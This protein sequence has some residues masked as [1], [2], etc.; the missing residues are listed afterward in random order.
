MLMIAVNNRVRKL[1]TSL[2]LVSPVA[3]M[4]S[5]HAGFGRLLIPPAFHAGVCCRSMP[6][7]CSGLAEVYLIETGPPC[8]SSQNTA[9]SIPGSIR[10]CARECRTAESPDPVDRKSPKV[11]AV[12]LDDNGRDQ[13][14]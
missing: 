7:T 6:S 10:A 3:L 2:F 13:I 14:V 9:C 11:S 1:V 5:Q 4:A 12:P 8:L